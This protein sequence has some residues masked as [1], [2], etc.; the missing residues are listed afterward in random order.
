L[1]RYVIYEAIAA[2]GMATV[3]FGRSIGLAG[4]SRLVAIKHL[5]PHLALDGAFTE[6]FLD[7]ARLAARVQHPNVVGT[8]DVLRH[9][10]DMFIVMEFVR[11]A[12]LAQVITA[13]RERKSFVPNGVVSSVVCDALRGLHEA[14]EARDELGASLQMVHRDISPQNVLVGVEGIARVADFGVAKAV[15]RLHSTA[16]DEVKGKLGYMSPEQLECRDVDRR[17]DLFAMG[18]VL[19]ELL[20]LRRLFVADDK[21]AVIG[22][23]LQGTIP[24]AAAHNPDASAFGEV[25]A[26]ALSTDRQSRFD[27]ALQMMQALE[28]AVPRASARDVSQWLSDLCGTSI[29]AQAQRIAAVEASSV[30]GLPAFGEATHDGP[31]LELPPVDAPTVVTASRLLEHATPSAASL[32][33][34]DED[35]PEQARTKGGGRSRRLWWA[36]T[37]VAVLATVALA[38]V[39]ATRRKTEQGAAEHSAAAS[40]PSLILSAS[41]PASSEPLPAP[42]GTPAV[43]AQPTATAGHAGQ[44]AQVAGQLGGQAT[45]TR[46]RPTPTASPPAAKRCN[47]PYTT[48][49][50]G[51]RRFKPE[52][53]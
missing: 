10:A 12:S 5:H 29:S 42:T 1:D 49:A 4:F 17:A 7:E 33:G 13:A 38:L 52:C 36:A 11:G 27:D 15:N 44:V 9:G 21:L 46:P 43:V 6:M 3:H 28:S 47:P 48:D 53:I 19:W 41:S 14:H 23:I 8:L 24:S 32:A 20:T 34:S 30:E 40:T 51:V 39:G 16:N 37:L 25:L 35:A 22:K 50:Q 2:G 26:R 45:A 31:S 18:V